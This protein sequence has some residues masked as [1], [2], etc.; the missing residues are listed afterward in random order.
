MRLLEN[1]RRY[2]K[3]PK[4]VLTNMYNHMKHRHT[5]EFTLKEFHQMFLCDNRYLRLYKE[6]VKNGYDKQFKPSLD[7]MNPKKNYSKENVQM[8]TWT[9]NRFKQSATDGK[10]GRKPRVIQMLGDKVIKIYQ[11]QRHAVKELGVSQGNISSVL[12]GKRQTT[13]G[14]KFIYENPEL[15]TQSIND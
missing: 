2:R 12:N 6:W 14:Y 7:R 5:V 10:L 4:G 11:S 15:L 3:T 13:M 1:T 9:E 8:L